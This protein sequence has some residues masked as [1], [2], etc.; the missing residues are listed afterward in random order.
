MSLDQ[1][2]LVRVG[3]KPGRVDIN[4]NIFLLD[5]VRGRLCG[6]SAGNIVVSRRHF[7]K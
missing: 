3:Q 7:D 1:V 6:C 2:R 4:R 5:K